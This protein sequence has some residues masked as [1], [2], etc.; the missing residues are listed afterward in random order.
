VKNIDRSK[1]FPRYAASIYSRSTP[2]DLPTPLL[3]NM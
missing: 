1:K 2:G 3:I